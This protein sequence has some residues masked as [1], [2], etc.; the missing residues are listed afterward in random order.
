MAVAQQA[1]KEQGAVVFDPIDKHIYQSIS[2]YLSEH[3][4]APVYRRYELSSHEAFIP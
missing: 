4:A 1:T 2:Q 3:D